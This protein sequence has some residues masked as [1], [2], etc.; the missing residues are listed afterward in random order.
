MKSS[1][2]NFLNFRKRILNAETVNIDFEIGYCCGERN[3]SYYDK[4]LFFY[5]SLCYAFL[6]VIAKER[7]IKTYR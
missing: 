6:K 4:H 1:Y 3:Q 5:W 2:Q 7:N